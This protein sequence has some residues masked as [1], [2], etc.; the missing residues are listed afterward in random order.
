MLLQSWLSCPYL[1][2]A[3]PFRSTDSMRT[4]K[5]FILAQLAGGAMIHEP[6]VREVAGRA[7]GPEFYS[8]SLQICFSLIGARVGRDLIGT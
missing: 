2:P 6:V 8:S 7:R 5:N 4:G 3:M 1:A